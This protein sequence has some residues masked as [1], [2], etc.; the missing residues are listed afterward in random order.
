MSGMVITDGR[1]G[2]LDTVRVVA[3][4]GRDIAVV[5]RRGGTLLSWRP[6]VGD[7][8]AD[9]VDGYVDEAELDTQA[10]VR[11]GLMAPF[12]NRVRDGRY[13]FDGEQ[14]QLQP[15]LAGQEELVFHGFLRV[16]D[17]ELV[18]TEVTD[19]AARFRL[20]THAIRPGGYA[21]YPFAV[22]LEVEY[23]VTPDELTLEVVGRNVGERVAPFGCGWHPYFRLGRH[24]VDPLELHVPARTR[25]RTDEALLPLAGDQAFVPVDEDDRPTYER[26]R[27]VADAVLDVAFADLVADDDGL[28]RT[29]LRDPESGRSLT[30]WQPGGLM[31]V[32][33]GDTLGRDPRASIALEPVELMTNA[34]ARPDCADAL[35]LPPGAERR[36]RFGVVAAT[37]D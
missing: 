37:A 20:A 1:F 29:R 28:V 11:N 33:T 21:G 35:A 10:G 13:S 22:D 6:A 15:V 9:L 27:P 14:H 19:S 17:C 2:N 30:V 32:F 34:Y 23:T 4:D 7:D 3:A 5:A 8:P 16:L 12:S 24:G 31:H 36:F 25:I 26:P 18:D